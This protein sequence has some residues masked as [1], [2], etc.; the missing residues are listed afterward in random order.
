MVN[1]FKCGSGQSQGKTTA[2]KDR[3]SASL[4][5]TSELAL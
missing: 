1:G 2:G 4:F 3:K 5:F